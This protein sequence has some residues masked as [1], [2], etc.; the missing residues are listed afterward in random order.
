MTL[1]KKTLLII[2]VTLV[3]LTAVLYTA[4]SAILTDSFAKVEQQST[5]RNVQRVQD[6]LADEV[7]KLNTQ[8]TD[9]AEWDASY[10]FIQNA[11][12]AYI[13]ETLTSEALTWVKLNLILYVN[14]SGR[15]VFATGFDLQTKT[16]MPVPASIQT[17]LQSG[18]LLLHQQG[19]DKHVAGLLLL[20]EGP[21]LIA[22]HA[23]LASTGEGARRG[24]LIMGRYLDTATVERLAQQTHLDLSIRRFGEPH[25]PDDFQAARTALSEKAS[26]F[27]RPLDEQ[28]IAGYTLLEDI[29]GQPGLLLRADTARDI[30]R[31]GQVSLQYLLASLVAGGLV[32]GAVALV[33][34]ERSVLSR[35][36]RLSTEVS[37]IGASGDLSTR[38]SM[39][40]RDEL[41]HLTGDING[42]LD[43]LQRFQT[44]R[45]ESEER[46]RV[47]VEQASEGILL[48]DAETK[49]VLEMNPAFQALL[50]YVGGEVPNLSLYDI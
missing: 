27:V 2:G 19:A 49:Q 25:L 14:S 32:F 28:E 10:A 29:F 9:W 15:T 18:R 44:Q 26:I 35:L 3:G 46:Y 47:V 11:D 34:L 8:V 48:V 1:R 39:T 16:A 33:L 22:A 30:Y 36:A 21:I 12:P 50:G 17:H 5:R 31:Q 4:L 13:K 42:M 43:A 37:A 23:I 45:R 40:G 24:T 6:A 20:P 7:D 41:S 38:L